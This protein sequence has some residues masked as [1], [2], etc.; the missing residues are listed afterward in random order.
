MAKMESDSLDGLFLA[1][2]FNGIST[3]VSYL[4]PK[5]PFKKTSRG[6]IKSIVKKIR[7]F[8]T[9]LMILVQK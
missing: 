6:I 7:G 3:F 9:F 8:I 1:S 4:V 2:L 5:L